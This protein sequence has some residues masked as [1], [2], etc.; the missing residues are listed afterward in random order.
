MR[1]ARP[2]YES[3]PYAYVV[4]GVAAV[5]ASF[6]WR[7]AHWSWMLAVAGV[8]AILGGLVLILRRRDYRIQRRHYGAVFDEDE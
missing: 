7:I 6:F 2:L 1:V 3:L 8:L 5:A 4:I